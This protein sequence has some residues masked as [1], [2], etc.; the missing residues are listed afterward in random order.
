M[1]S[2]C[3]TPKLYLS[4]HL[5]VCFCLHSEEEDLQGDDS[6]SI[7]DSLCTEITDQNDDS[8]SLYVP[9]TSCAVG[10]FEYPVC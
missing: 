8:V 10:L 5:F 1:F 2:K 3:Q 6:Q 4:F 7:S 9:C